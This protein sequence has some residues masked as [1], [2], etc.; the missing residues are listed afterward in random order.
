GPGS[1][2]RALIEGPGSVWTQDVELF[3]GYLGAGEMTIRD[4]GVV[5]TK[6]MG[7]IGL[8]SGSDGVVTIDGPGSRWQIDGLFAVGVA[9][10]GVLT[11]SNGGALETNILYVSHTSSADGV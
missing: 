9:Q 10:S 7:A 4:G 1:H 6:G 2:G 5:H 11:V 3:V 8:Y